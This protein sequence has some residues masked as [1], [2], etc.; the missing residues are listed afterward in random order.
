MT[1]SQIAERAQ[2]A[3]V[4]ILK[5]DDVTVTVPTLIPDT[6]SVQRELQAHVNSGASRQEVA[7]EFFRIFYSDPAQYLKE[8]ELETNDARLYSLGSGFIV[9]PDGFVLTNAH[10]VVSDDDELKK[11]AVDSIEGLVNARAEQMK[12]AVE[13]LLPGSTVADEASER[14]KSTLRDQYAKLGQF[15]VKTQIKVLMPSAPGDKADQ[16][17]MRDCTVKKIGKATPGKDVAVLKMDGTNLP[18]LSLAKSLESAGVGPGSDLYVMG[19][20]GAVSLAPIF[21]NPR[22]VQASFSGGHVSEVRDMTE[23]WQAIQTDAVIN[24]GNSGGPVFNNKGQ[25]VGLATFQLKDG[26]GLN[27]AVS[28]DLARQF[29]SELHVTP[30]QSEFSTEYDRAMGA[31]DRSD[32]GTALKLFQALKASHSDLSGPREFVRKLSGG[33]NATASSTSI[34][35]QSRRARGNINPAVYLAGGIGVLLLAILG[36]IVASN[37]R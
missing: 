25:V 17:D 18:T 1:P 6:D 35:Q 27:F 13:R 14:L 3:T 5:M 31:Y 16:V 10:V 34:G 22:Q 8:G 12:A 2:P 4:E 11:T 19:Y 32:R 29:L 26:Q 23:G 36:I 21:A 20:P 33:E 15:D 24:P 28:V 7:E 37:R 9:T 30:N